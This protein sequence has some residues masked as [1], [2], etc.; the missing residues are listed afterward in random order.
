MRT[1]NRKLKTTALG[2][3]ALIALSGCATISDTEM[4]IHDENDISVIATYAYDT[5]TYTENEWQGLLDSVEEEMPEEIKGD[6]DIKD[7]KKDNLDGRTYSL[8]HKTLDEQKEYSLGIFSDGTLVKEGNKYVGNFDI[9]SDVDESAE[10]VTLKVTA[11]GKITD[12]PGANI[13]GKTATWNLSEYSEDTIHFEA[14]KSSAGILIGLM[15]GLFVAAGIVLAVVWT[16]KGNLGK[17]NAGASHGPSHGPVTDGTAGPGEYTA[18]DIDDTHKGHSP[19][20]P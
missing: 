4:I 16:R 10:T 7:Y 12:A 1:I 3:G 8:E 2:I 17:K 19:G 11:P 6:V 14:Q 20:S 5:E 18:K 13:D 15:I 9:A